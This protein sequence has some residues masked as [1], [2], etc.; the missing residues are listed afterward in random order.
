MA[1]LCH[2][3]LGPQWLWLGRLDGA[4][5]ACLVAL[6]V[7][8]CGAYLAVQWDHFQTR[9]ALAER[10][11]W[12]GQAVGLALKRAFGAQQPLVAVT[13]AGTIPYWSELPALDMLGLNDRY[14]AHNPPEDFGQHNLGHELGDADYVLRRKPDL[15]IYHIGHLRSRL[16]AGRE[17][18]ARPEFHEQYEAVRFVAREPSP[19]RFDAWVRRDSE[20]IGIRREGDRI[21]IPGYLF[22]GNRGSIA[23]LDEDGQFVVAV[24][25]AEPAVLIGLELRPG[26]WRLE[27]DASWETRLAMRGSGAEPV[28]V[29]RLGTD[30]FRVAGEGIARVDVQVG[31]APLTRAELRSVTLARLGP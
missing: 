1:T 13:S 4:S 23:S 15:L 6:L 14:L 7:A 16:R 19:Q 2:Q 10:F 22:N 28:A 31:A 29:T 5:R 3:H 24:T 30:V 27:T 12:E 26:R 8:S 18:D 21:E 11:E 17:L 25:Q 9:R 20:K